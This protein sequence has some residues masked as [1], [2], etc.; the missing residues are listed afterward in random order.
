[1]VVRSFGVVL[2][3]ALAARQVAWVLGAGWD[4]RWADEGYVIV[5]PIGYLLRAVP[6]AF[7]GCLGALT[8]LVAR[9]DGSRWPYAFWIAG[10]ILVALGFV[11]ATAWVGWTPPPD[12]YL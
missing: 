11:V 1:M 7:F 6:G 2:G 8:L 5:Q 12:P 9:D 4:G 10:V 3:F